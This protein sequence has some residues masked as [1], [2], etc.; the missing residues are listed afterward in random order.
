MTFTCDLLSSCYLKN[1][2]DPNLIMLI[3]KQIGKSKKAHLMKVLCT[4]FI[5]FVFFINYHFITI[6]CFLLER[7]KKSNF[8][9]WFVNFSNYFHEKCHPCNW[10]I[11]HL[12][13]ESKNHVLLVFVKKLQFSICLCRTLNF[14]VQQKLNILFIFCKHICQ[15]HSIGIV[16]KY[17]W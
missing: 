12:T 17:Y 5:I 4:Y 11:V 2:L 15:S 8:F 1:R 13:Q 3:C 6:K 7:M 9:I 10:N 16:W 14:I